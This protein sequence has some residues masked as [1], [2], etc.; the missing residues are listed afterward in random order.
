MW[1]KDPEKPSKW[2]LWYEFNS[3]ISKVK[4]EHSH[5]SVSIPSCVHTSFCLIIKL[6]MIIF[7]IKSCLAFVFD[8]CLKLWC[9]YK[10]FCWLIFC[11]STVLPLN[12]IINC[13]NHSFRLERWNDQVINWWTDISLNWL[14]VQGIF[15]NIWWFQLLRCENLLVFPH[16]TFGQR[17]YIRLMF[18]YLRYILTQNHDNHLITVQLYLQSLYKSIL[19]SSSLNTIWLVQLSFKPQNAH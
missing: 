15:L 3:A 9:D 19:Q 11:Q 12:S 10:H 18:F 17:E 2:T 7:I 1:L 8:K 16:L 13:F 4:N 14:D 5:S 6:E